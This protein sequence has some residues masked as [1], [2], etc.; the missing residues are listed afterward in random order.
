MR[1][2]V[3][4]AGMAGVEHQRLPRNSFCA[5]ILSILLE[6]KS[7]HRKDA[8]I[9]GQLSRPVWQ[10]PRDPI[11]HAAPPAKVEV[12][13]VRDR[14]RQNVVRPVGK[15]GAIQGD[16]MNRIALEPSAR[17]PGVTSCGIV[18]VGACPLDGGNARRER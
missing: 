11:A 17:S 5:P 4:G 15:E 6:G 16:R 8:R 1:D 3:N 9:T 13:R 10:R 14:Q 12:E 2:D 18:G 7:V